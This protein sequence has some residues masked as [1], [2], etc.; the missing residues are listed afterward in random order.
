[1]HNYIIEKDRFSTGKHAAIIRVVD[2]VQ[3]GS[4]EICKSPQIRARK[5]CTLGDMAHIL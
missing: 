1:M 2:S 3:S 5:S 4:Q